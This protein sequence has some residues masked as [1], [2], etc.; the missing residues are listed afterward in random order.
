MH[1][2]KQY[3]DSFVLWNQW[4][5]VCH[6]VKNLTICLNLSIIEFQRILAIYYV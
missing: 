6:F 4:T 2:Q 5:K 1:S 3:S